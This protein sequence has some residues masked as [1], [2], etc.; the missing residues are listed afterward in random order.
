[1]PLFLKTAFFIVFSAAFFLSSSLSNLGIIIRQKNMVIFML[2]LVAVY[3]LG[4]DQNR[5]KKHILKRHVN[6]QR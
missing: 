4:I 2:V 5:N 1:M 3:V 6:H